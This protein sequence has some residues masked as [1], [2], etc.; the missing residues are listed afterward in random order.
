MS[1]LS[2]GVLPSEVV[3]DIGKQMNEIKS[4][5][6]NLKSTKPPKDYTVEH[7]KNWLQDLKN[8]PD[9]KAIHILIERIDIKNKTEIN[10]QSTLNTV[11]GK[12]GCGGWI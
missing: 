12:T 9:E 2:T 8:N 7:I 4:E 3:A 6:A 1:N 5:I 11:L 10:I